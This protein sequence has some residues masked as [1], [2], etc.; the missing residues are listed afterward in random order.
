MTSVFVSVLTPFSQG[1]R[2]FQ[3]LSVLASYAPQRTIPAH[4]YL[5]DLESFFYVIVYIF[6]IH[7]PDGSRV[8]S[9]EK[10]PLIVGKWDDPDP[11][12]AHRHKSGVFASW[13]GVRASEIV[14]TT[15]GPVCTALYKKFRSWTSNM[16]EDK[17]DSLIRDESRDGDEDEDEDDDDDEDE[18]AQTYESLLSR[19]DEHYFQVLRIF[20]EAIDS[21]K[22]PAASDVAPAATLPAEVPSPSAAENTEPSTPLPP[23]EHPS[24]ET[25]PLVATSSSTPS[26]SLEAPVPTTPPPAAPSAFA[27]YSNP[28][29][30]RLKRRSEDAVHPESPPS[31]GRRVTNALLVTSRSP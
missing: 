12:A 18:D 16:R 25:S 1:T 22:A 20:D 11:S 2:I 10:G 24:P 31:K 4:D 28:S 14:E 5:D 21:L 29:S 9:R 7:R 30:P 3:S 15:W 26:S 17:I 13:E 6:L 8:P 19:R 27:V 23:P